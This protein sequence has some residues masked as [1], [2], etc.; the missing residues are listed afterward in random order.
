MSLS[1]FLYDPLFWIVLFL[2]L[3]VVAS[4]VLLDRKERGREFEER[5]KSLEEK[6][7]KLEEENKNQGLDVLF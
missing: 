1:Y 5:L 7:N 6:Q 2:L 4:S 3:I